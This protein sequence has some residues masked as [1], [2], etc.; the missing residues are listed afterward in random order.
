[1]NLLIF[2]YEHMAIEDLREA[3]TN[4]GHTYTVITDE[5][6]Y[7]H[8]D[9]AFDARFD[10]LIESASYDAVFAFNYF[11]VISN[12][13]K[14][15]N[16]PYIA[17]VY[18][19]PL[20]S[21]Y[22]YT[23]INPCNYVFLFDQQTYLE[24]KKEN[25]QTVYYMP[26]AVNTSRLDKM[27]ASAVSAS[28]HPLDFYQSDISFVGTMYNEVH[29]L[30]DRM[31]HLSDYTKGYLQGIMQAQMKVYGY[32]FIE[33][34][35]SKEIIED[36]QHSLPLQPGNDSVESTEWLFAHYVI[37]RKI[38]NLE[39]TSLL[40]SA[41]EHFN[42]KLFTPN[43]TPELPLIHNMGSVDYQRQMPYVFKNSAINLNIS[44]R[45]IR[46]GIPLRCF[47]IMG[48]G[49]FLLSNYQGDFYEHFVPGEDLVLFE[50][51]E[52]FLNKCDYYLKHDNER[53]QIAA[54]GYGKVKEFHTYEVRLK[55]IFEVVFSK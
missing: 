4:L 3:L 42:T 41:S 32:Y 15:H 28:R 12:C 33:E 26:L 17:F 8:V 49:G 45:S 20:V 14:K 9:E 50:S 52:D 51:Q 7:N 40:K 54:N 34:L 2:E 55:E 27:T 13:C 53:R 25:I 10:K 29:N 18:D 31:E 46:S 37:A 48:C 30:F 47:D 21:L 5:N 44:L 11:P 19:S 43:P 38:A 36:M 24:L 6:I 35:L 39:R 1:M 23:I 22:S 16:I